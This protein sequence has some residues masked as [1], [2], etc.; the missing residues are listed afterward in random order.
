VDVPQWPL[1]N[2][3]GPLPKE[4]EQSLLLELRTAKNAKQAAVSLLS[5]T[6]SHP[7]A[8]N[9]TLHSAASDPS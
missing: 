7:Q 2:P 4:S 6:Y 1:S 5:T 9:P 3:N 8:D